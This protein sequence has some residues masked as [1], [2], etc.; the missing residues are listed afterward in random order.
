MLEEKEK[1]SSAFLTPN[2]TVPHHSL[3]CNTHG[4]DETKHFGKAPSFGNLKSFHL[5][6][7]IST[8]EARVATP[9]RNTL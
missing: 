6:F 8:R 4:E 5:K 9:L 7:S 1:D 3:H 2:L